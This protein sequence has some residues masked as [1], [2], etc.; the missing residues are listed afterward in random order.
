VKLLGENNEIF[1]GIRTSKEFWKNAPKAQE[2][3]GYIDK[4]HCMKLI[5]FHTAK[6][7]LN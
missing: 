3:K 5:R 6:K 4:C 2:T 1:G 7:T